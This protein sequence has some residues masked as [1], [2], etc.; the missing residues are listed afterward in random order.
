[1]ETRGRLTEDHRQTMNVFEMTMIAGQRGKRL[2]IGIRFFGQLSGRE[3]SLER[4]REKRE[5][6]RKRCEE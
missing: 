5:R 1:M 4:A 6:E 2:S 3:W